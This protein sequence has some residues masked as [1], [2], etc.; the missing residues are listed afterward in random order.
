M[1]TTPMLV[2]IMPARTV[3]GFM[4]PLLF[5]TDIFALFHYWKRWEKSNIARLIPGTVL[6]IAV[7]GFI[8]NDISDLYLKKVIG[9]IACFFALLEFIRARL[10]TRAGANLSISVRLKVWHGVIAGVLTG[11]FSTLA[12]LGGLVVT[13]Y[14][15]PQRLP[16]RAFVGTTTAIYFLINLF[17]I[18]FYIQLGLFTFDS[19]IE[20]VALLPYIALGVI[21]GI[22]MNQRIPRGIF[23]RVILFLV[24]A[25]GVRLLL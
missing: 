14:L 16:N 9:G 15:L 8:L 24:F 22:F 10:T 11:L 21:T 3:V 20:N 17:K 25:A 19:L 1:I 5:A 2:S 6:G 7:G 4:L 18:P 12:R 13:M 23:A